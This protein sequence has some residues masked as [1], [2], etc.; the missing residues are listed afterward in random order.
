MGSAAKWVW[1]AKI[2]ECLFGSLVVVCLH[3]Q[4]EPT[5]F[6]LVPCIWPLAGKNRCDVWDWKFRGFE[7]SLSTSLHGSLVVISKLAHQKQMPS[8]HLL[9]P[10]DMLLPTVHHPSKWPF[11]QWQ[12]LRTKILGFIFGFSLFLTHHI[13]LTKI[14][15]FRICPEHTIS[16]YFHCH[17]PRLSHHLSMK[18][19]V[20]SPCINQCSPLQ[21]QITQS[22]SDFPSHW[23]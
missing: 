14:P 21:I 22:G 19:L 9:S 8:I 15:Y 13:Q 23:E 18:M 3:L 10:S 7:L 5:Q 6:I 17:G 20:L 11:L 16:Y 12:L 1:K 4:T 2:S